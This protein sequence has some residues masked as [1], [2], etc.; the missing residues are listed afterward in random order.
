M[1][2]K[3]FYKLDDVPS[4]DFPFAFICQIVSNAAKAEHEDPRIVCLYRKKV[5]L[6]VMDGKTPLYGNIFF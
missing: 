5:P 2:I 3:K 4:L 6:K 1:H